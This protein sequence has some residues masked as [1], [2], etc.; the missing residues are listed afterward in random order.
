MLKK[1]ISSAL[2]FTMLT[3]IVMTSPVSAFVTDE[4]EIP[5]QLSTIK[6]VYEPGKS[7]FVSNSNQKYVGEDNIDGDKTQGCFAPGT[8]NSH[9]RFGGLWQSMGFAN[10]VFYNVFGEMPRFGYHCN[11]SELNENV[12][13]IVRYASECRYLRG[14]TDGE[15]TAENIDNLMSKAKQGDILVAAPKKGCKDVGRAMVIM[16]V[17]DGFVTVYHT[18]F[19][20]NCAVT[21]DT[22]AFDALANFHCLTLLRSADYPYPQ[23]VPPEK[24]DKITLSDSDFSLNENVNITWP[25][26][27]YASKY[28]VYLLNENDEIVQE[29]SYRSSVTSFVFKQP[30]KYRVKVVAN[31]EYGD[32]E[33]TYSDEIVVHN[34]NVVT[35]KDYDGTVITTQKVE[36][37]KDA[38][39]P[40]VPQRKGYQFAGWD[41][42]LENI[43]EPT[44]ITATYEVMSYTIKYYDVGGKS[45]LSAETV[46]Y[47]GQATPPTNYTIDEGYVF[48]GWQISFDSEGT[49]Y[50]CVDGDMTLIATQKWEN[51]NLPISISVSDA[52]RDTTATYYSADLSITNHDLENSKNFKII[53]TLKSAEGKALK[54]VVLDEVNLAAGA[55]KILSDRT[56]VYS[57]KATTIEFVAVG[58]VGNSKTGGSFSKIASTSILDNSSWGSWTEWTT[59]EKISSYDDYETKTQYRYRNKSYTTSTSASLN[60]WTKYNTTSST[61]SWSGWSNSYIAEIR[62]DAQYREVGTQYIAPTYKTQYHYFSWYKGSSA[63]WTHYSSSHP[64]LAEIWIDYQLPFYKYSGGINQYG[65]SGYSFGYPFNR[66]LIAD[67]TTY[68]LPSSSTPYF[69]RQVQTGGGYTQY[70][71]RD[72][73]YTYYFWKWGDW[74]SWSD[75]YKSGDDT[76]TR[77][78]Y[79]YRNRS[80]SGDVEDSTGEFFD[81]S[82]TLNN[83]ESDFSGMTASVM[84]YKKCN[85]DPTEEQL[86]Y[87]GE[88]TIGENNSYSF[89]F[90]PKEMPSSETGEFIVALGIEGA[91]RLVNVDVIE[92]DVPTYQVKFVADGIAIED[93]NAQEITDSDG[94]TFKAQLVKE[95][96]TAIAPEPPEKEGYTFVKWSETLTGIKTDKVITAEYEPNEYT[97]VFIDWDTNNV[98]TQ[99]LKYGDTIVYPDLDTV[100]G[101]NERTWDK[102]KEGV[103]LVTDN[104]IIGSVSTLNEYTVTFM[105]G[106]QIIETQTVEHGGAAILPSTTPSIEGMKFA[107]WVGDCSY[108]Y[109][110]QDVT[111]TPSFYYTKTVSLPEATVTNIAADGSTTV[112]LSCDTEGA[113]IYYVIESHD[114]AEMLS[115]YEE[116]E[117]GICTCEDSVHLFEDAEIII[118]ETDFR[119]FATEYTG[120][121]ELASNETVTF[122]AY[123]DGMNE[124]IPAIESNE[125][126]NS[127][128]NTN[129]KENGL[130]QYKNSVE[131]YLSVN[132]SNGLPEYEHGTISLCFYDH[133]GVMIDIIPK[134]IEVIPGENIVEFNDINLTGNIVKNADKITCRV[135]SW[136][137]GEKIVPISDVIEFKLD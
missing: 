1:L 126:E 81:V 115:V 21:E 34:Q 63:P 41:K 128:Y 70:R 68:G 37:G 8:T 108:D 101:A 6:S 5:Q 119:A 106:E 39:A 118:P 20:G 36:Y 131:G 74:S 100:E 87:V 10:Y 75:T 17:M 124:S 3:T 24:V 47:E 104:M 27:K 35:F 62:T 54:I 93:D 86:E 48:A 114:E 116:V 33:A 29:G 49:D 12:D 130:R 94:N 44:E 137:S 69:T 38:T 112:K 77:T 61:G 18:D 111:F 7:Y 30:G 95:G 127:Y 98:S 65:G 13:V 42:S 2:A 50:N 73:Y 57:E 85:T 99:K 72:T 15:V 78:L 110:T 79:R 66:W 133:R 90:K 125:T 53:G 103:Q 96:E 76:G 51:L 40:N 23:P 109:I 107:D 134:T 121:I 60:G 31:N 55:S 71:Y 25:I 113:K 89:T 129:I 135:V 91:D 58:M 4:D 84:V 67:G 32:S 83:V 46:A 97:L 45:V 64:Y 80:D 120:E 88:T 59:E 43:K 14:K 105:N 92:A 132:I 52:F 82:G 56:I 16:N 122:I 117:G 136:L 26:K 11:P 19:K 9:G 22:I 123:A 28:K 102:Q